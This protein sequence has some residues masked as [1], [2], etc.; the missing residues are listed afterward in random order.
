METTEIK[1]KDIA[2]EFALASKNNDIELL[3]T[4]LSKDGTFHI[5]NQVLNTIEVGRE[6]FLRW[7]KEKLD[8]TNI[9][10][11]EYDQCL[12]CLLG[13]PV[14]LFNNGRFPRQVKDCGERTKTGLALKIRDNKIAEMAFCYSLLKIENKPI[15]EG[16]FKRIAKYEKA[17]MPRKEAIARGRAEEAKEFNLVEGKS[18]F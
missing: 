8:T 9:E 10:S 1:T 17:G 18:K 3:K 5:Q 14:V 15:F 16:T 11:I 4:L 13:N 2:V 12:F 7:Y 6:E